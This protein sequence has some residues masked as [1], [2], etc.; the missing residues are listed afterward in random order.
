MGPPPYFTASQFLLFQGSVAVHPPLS[1][2]DYDHVRRRPGAQGTQHR[3][4]TKFLSYLGVLAADESSRQPVYGHSSHRTMSFKRVQPS[5][6]PS[7]YVLEDEE[8]D[9]EKVLAEEA[10]PIPRGVRYTGG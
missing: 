4:I 7:I 1:A 10:I 5:T 3:S 6:G 8:I 9:F 2:D